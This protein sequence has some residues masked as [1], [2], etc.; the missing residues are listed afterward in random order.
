[1]YI[2]FQIEDLTGLFQ[3]FNINFPLSGVSVAKRC[4]SMNVHPFLACLLFCL[5]LSSAEQSDSPDIAVILSREKS[6]KIK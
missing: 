5:E 4:E 1:M 6:M 2:V 3:L